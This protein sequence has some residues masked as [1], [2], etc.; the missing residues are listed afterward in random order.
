MPHL[1]KFCH[2][3]KWVL[4]F[5]VRNHAHGCPIYYGISEIVI[6]VISKTRNMAHKITSSVRNYLGFFLYSTCILVCMGFI[7]LHMAETEALGVGL[8]TQIF[9]LKCIYFSRKTYDQQTYLKQDRLWVCG[10]ET[11]GQTFVTQ[12]V[13][14]LLRCSIYTKPHIRWEKS[15]QLCTTELWLNQVLWGKKK[16]LKELPEARHF[17]LAR[18]L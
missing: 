2:D 8:S 5:H 3:F 9:S 13:V 6:L 12:L 4:Q 11:G 1:S 7:I 17:C 15:V 16:A 10:S 18:N 14:F